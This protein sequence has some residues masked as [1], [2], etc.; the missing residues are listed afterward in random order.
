MYSHLRLPIM[1]MPNRIRIKKT[2]RIRAKQYHSFPA[3]NLQID[4]FKTSKLSEQTTGWYMH[5]FNLLTPKSAKD[6]NSYIIPNFI[7]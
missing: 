7:L 2:K 4:I 5:V 3:K 1:G 6:K